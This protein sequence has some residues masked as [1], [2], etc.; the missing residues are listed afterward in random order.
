MIRAFGL[1]SNATNY[2]D[3]LKEVRE[4]LDK[5]EGK[6]TPIITVDGNK[7][8][9]KL[10]DGRE[11]V[12]RCNPCDKF[13]IIEGI[14]VA[15]DDIERKSVVKLSDE[16]VMYLK[17]AKKAGANYVRVDKWNLSKN[18]IYMTVHA[19][20]GDENYEDNVKLYFEDDKLFTSLKNGKFYL[21]NTLLQERS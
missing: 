16:E 9:V 7:T 3:A 14:R 12:A 18:D 6:T 4:W 10:P 11:G 20:L 17:V 15:L 1:G 5:E 2:K 8:T 13:D 19:E 21:I